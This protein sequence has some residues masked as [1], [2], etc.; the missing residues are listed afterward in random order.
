MT[1]LSEVDIKTTQQQQEGAAN[2]KARP[3]KDR[4]RPYVVVV[5]VVVVVVLTLTL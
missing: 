1:G 4:A 2:P 3:A 5:V